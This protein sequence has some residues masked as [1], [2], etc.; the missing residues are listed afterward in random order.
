MKKG[1]SIAGFVLWAIGIGLFGFLSYYSL[2][3]NSTNV[4]WDEGSGAYLVAE[5]ITPQTITAATPMLIAMA[6]ML[7]ALVFGLVMYLRKKRYNWLF[8]VPVII[9]LF[10]LLACS[11]NLRVV[12]LY[13]FSFL[14]NTLARMLKYIPFVLGLILLL[15]TQPSQKKEEE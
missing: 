10:F 9:S 7:A 1:L 4:T 6:F 15:F 2:W 12:E 14:G 5:Q 13:Y 8:Y 11:F 3:Y